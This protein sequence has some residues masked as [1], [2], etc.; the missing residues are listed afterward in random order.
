[1]LPN[2]ARYIAVSAHHMSPVRFGGV[3]RRERDTDARADAG[4]H[5][6]QD[7][8]LADLAE[9]AL[10]DRGGRVGVGV[11]QH[12]REFVAAQ[13]KDRA[14]R[15]HRPREARTEL[16]QQLVA[17]RVTE[18]VVDLLEVVEVDEEERQIRSS[19]S[20]DWRSRR[21]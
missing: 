10:G 8:R 16:T 19:S 21:R 3:V 12:D 20:T 17:G 14:G 2:L 4:A 6:V 13:T 11:D 1:M 5:L 18:G 7:E 9:D 15:R